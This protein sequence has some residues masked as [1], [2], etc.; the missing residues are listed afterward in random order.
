LNS[1]VAFG[2]NAIHEFSHAFGFLSDEYIDGRDRANDRRN[3]DKPSVFTLSNLTFSDRDDSVAW[4][5]LAPTGRFRRTGGRKPPPVAGWLW[6]GGVVHTGAWHSEYRCLMNGTHDNYAFTQVAAEDPTANADG[7]YTD[8]NG[9]SLR[10]LDRF[11]AWRQ[12]IVTIRLQEKTDQLTDPGDPSDPT[13]QGRASFTRWESECRENYY[14][15]LFVGQ[16]I[17]DVETSYAAMAPGLH[18]E[19]LWQSDLYR[20][21]HASSTQETGPVHVLEDGETYLLLGYTAIPWAQRPAA[22]Q[23]AS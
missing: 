12:E 1:R 9:A 10:D 5:H 21:P 2:A 11:C 20:V 15:A 6:V 23:T 7:S 16:Q 3:P 4:A 13:E 8:E 22:G 14:A 18:G 17:R 19:P